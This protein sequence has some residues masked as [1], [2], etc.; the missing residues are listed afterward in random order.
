MNDMVLKEATNIFCI[1]WKWEKQMRWRAEIQLQT[2]QG[3]VTEYNP[4]HAITPEALAAK[5]GLTS[6]LTCVRGGNSKASSSVII[7]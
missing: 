5:F 4:Q 2:P 1:G 3:A 6:S 7:N